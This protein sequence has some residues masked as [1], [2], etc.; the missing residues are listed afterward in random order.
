MQRAPAFLVLIVALLYFAAGSVTTREAVAQEQAGAQGPHIAV[1]LPL[2]S[3]TLGRLAD[4]VRRGVLEAHRVH[5]GSGLPVCGSR[6][7][8]APRPGSG[9]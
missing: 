6:A 1:L 7:T 3:P 2:Q 8:M 4:A 9:A 5:T